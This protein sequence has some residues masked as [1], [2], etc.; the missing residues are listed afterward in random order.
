VDLGV[1][2]GRDGIPGT[3]DDLRLRDVVEQL[4]TK[5]IV[6]IA[7]YD[8]ATWLQNKAM[9]DLAI[10]GFEFMARRTGGLTKPIR[11]AKEVPKAI[12]S[13]V[14]ESYLSKP[15]LRVPPTYQAWVSVSPPAKAGG[16]NAQFDF[17]LSL[18]PPDGTPDGIYRFPVRA[19][20]DGRAGGGEIGRTWITIRIGLANYAWRWPLLFAYLFLTSLLL[21]RRLGREAR[22]AIRYERNG[23]FWVLLWRLSAALLTVSVGYLIWALAPGTLPDVPGR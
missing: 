13:G 17:A 5:G 10:Q 19:V 3:P 11:S 7:V 15:G 2:P 14:R 20:H 6:M 22:R 8:S 12:A 1:D 4:A 16:S 9:L 23:Q 18:R 21:A